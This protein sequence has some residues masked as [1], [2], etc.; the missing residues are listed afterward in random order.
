MEDEKILMLEYEIEQGRNKDWQKQ[1]I[2]S[3]WRKWKIGGSVKREKCAVA[4]KEGVCCCTENGSMWG[5]IRFE[6]ETLFK[7]FD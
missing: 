3:G 1:E 5:E 6:R 2:K 7:L 4:M